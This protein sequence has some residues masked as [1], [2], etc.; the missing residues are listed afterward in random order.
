[1]GD[2]DNSQVTIAELHRAVAEYDE[3]LIRL[4]Q[5]ASGHETIYD[6]YRTTE[7]A[8]M[9]VAKRYNIPANVLE[10]MWL[11]H[12]RISRQAGPVMYQ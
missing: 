10:K 12:C 4:Y 8:R 9:A 1:M 11:I 5:N 7:V 3:A 2:M 6:L